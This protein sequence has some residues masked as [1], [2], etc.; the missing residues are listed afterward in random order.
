M[1]V[2]APAGEH[3]LLAERAPGLSPVKMITAGSPPPAAVIQGLEGLGFDVMHVYGLTEVYGP[4]ASCAWNEEAWGGLSALEK[5][6][7]KAQQVRSLAKTLSMNR[8]KFGRG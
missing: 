3:A 8:V 4:A 2:H 1:M 7:V 6:D 5:A